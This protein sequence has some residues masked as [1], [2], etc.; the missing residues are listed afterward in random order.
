MLNVSK[1]CASYGGITAVEDV[2]LNVERGQFVALLGAN[3]AGKSTTL[4]ALTGLHSVRSGDVPFPPGSDPRRD[5]VVI[6]T[7][8]AIRK[9][10]ELTYDYGLW[11]EGPFRAA[12]LRQAACRTVE[13]LMAGL[14]AVARHLVANPVRVGLVKSVGAY[15]YWDSVWLDGQHESA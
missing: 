14:L 11:F 10:E 2:S 5:R 15:P 12:W 1:L 8:R 4:K 13:L 3:G 7:K 9:G 6:D